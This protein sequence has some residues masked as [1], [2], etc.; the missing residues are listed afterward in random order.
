MWF[1][2]G[3][4]ALDHYIHAATICNSLALLISQGSSK[5]FAVRIALLTTLQKCWLNGHSI[6]QLVCS[7]DGAIEFACSVVLHDCSTDIVSDSRLCFTED[8]NSLDIQSSELHNDNSTGEAWLDCT[9]E[10][11]SEYLN[12]SDIVAE[13]SVVSALGSETVLLFLLCIL[14]EMCSF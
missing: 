4:K 5:D 7:S 10:V 13:K 8:V 14:C 3:G 9:L 11:K 12:A 6:Q 2:L 1:T